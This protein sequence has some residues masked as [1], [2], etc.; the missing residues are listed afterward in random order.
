MRQ[1]GWWREK[2]PFVPQISTSIP[3][4]MPRLGFSQAHAAAI[5]A[6]L[7]GEVQLA[8]R[9]AL[10][11]GLRV[12]ELAR[13]RIEV[14]FENKTIKIVG[15]NAK[16]GRQRIVTRLLDPTVLDDVPRDRNYVFTN[17]GNFARVA[18]RQVAAARDAAGISAGTGLGMHAFRATYAEQFLRRAITTDGLTEAAARRALT[19]QLGHFSVDVTYRY[20]PKIT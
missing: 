18:Q 14:D 17:P 2:E 12:N 16:G 4:S 15:S 13:L 7:T 10:S 8:A 19:L 6:N 5:V 1:R 9:L 11:S 20:C 3:R